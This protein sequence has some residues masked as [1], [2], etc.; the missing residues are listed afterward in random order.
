VS[1]QGIAR[2]ELVKALQLKVDKSPQPSEYSVAE[3][4]W[5]FTFM[6]V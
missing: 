4:V 3:N 1:P 5:S 2:Q 6:P